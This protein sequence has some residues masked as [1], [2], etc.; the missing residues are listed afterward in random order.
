MPLAPR[1]SEA[2]GAER[3]EHPAL[4]AVMATSLAIGPSIV[5]VR[6]PR[7]TGAEVPRAAVQ[8]AMS[9]R[10]PIPRGVITWPDDALP[11]GA[12]DP[13]MAIDGPPPFRTLRDA[14]LRSPLRERVESVLFGMMLAAVLAG[15]TLGLVEVAK[16]IA[17]AQF[18]SP[19]R[20]ATAGKVPV[21]ETRLLSVQLLE[22]TPSRAAAV[23]HARSGG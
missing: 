18:D 5:N 19:V 6:N 21:V 13:A 23:S 17:D 4:E 16:T 22:E 15:S 20:T 7:A 2:D 1:A 11:V 8:H 12:G 10:P 9:D 14:P 3:A